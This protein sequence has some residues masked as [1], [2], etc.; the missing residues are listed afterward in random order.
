MI[1][2]SIK[3]KFLPNYSKKYWPGLIEAYKKYLPVSSKTPVITLK[4]G[5]TPLIHSKKL[6]SLIDLTIESVSKIL[7]KK[8]KLIFT[9]LIKII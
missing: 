9:N 1:L 3:E 8:L 5:N 7:H 6:S 4:E 2:N